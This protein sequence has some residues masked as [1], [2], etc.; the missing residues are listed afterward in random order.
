MQLKKI[1]NLSL[2]ALVA[3]HD[4][5]DQEAMEGPHQSLWYSTL[6]GDGGTQVQ[7]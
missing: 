4:H 5:E 2:V 3:C 1:L 6:P 7:I